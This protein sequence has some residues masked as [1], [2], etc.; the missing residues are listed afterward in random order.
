MQGEIDLL[1]GEAS[2]QPTAGA[3]KFWAD[4]LKLRGMKLTV[5]RQ[6][7]PDSKVIDY[8]EPGEGEIRWSGRAD[9]LVLIKRPEASY[10]LVKVKIGKVEGFVWAH[11]LAVMDED[12]VTP[13][14]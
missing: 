9:G 8:I 12:V 6:G 5:H 11:N 2:G 4:P 1:T 13:F 3:V 14:K 10:L 7:S